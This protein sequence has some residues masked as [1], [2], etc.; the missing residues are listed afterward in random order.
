MTQL[1]IRILAYGLALLLIVGGSIWFG[2]H[3]T[4]RH[5]QALIA[6][7][8][9]AQTQALVDA[10]AKVIAAQQAQEQATQQAEKQYEDLKAHYDGLSQRLADSVRAYAAL[11]TL[12]VPKATPAASGPDGAGPGTGSDQRLANLSGLAAQGCLHDAAELTALQSWSK[13]VSIQH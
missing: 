10:Q 11:R 5:Y 8:K 12:I 9:A 1:E 4:A 13:A 3:F 6:R 2:Y 7:D